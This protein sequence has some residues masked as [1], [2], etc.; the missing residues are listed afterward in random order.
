[1]FTHSTVFAPYAGICLYNNDNKWTLRTAAGLDGKESIRKEETDEKPWSGIGKP[2]YRVA[3]E[4]GLSA[5][6]FM[7]HNAKKTPPEWKGESCV[8][9][10]MLIRSCRYLHEEA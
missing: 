6:R 8:L 1:M 10:N 4:R 2:N 5:G 9:L 3:E 7:M